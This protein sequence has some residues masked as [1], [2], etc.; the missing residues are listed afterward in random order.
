[1]AILALIAGV[2]G[3]VFGFSHLKDHAGGGGAGDDDVLRGDGEHFGE[4]SVSG[5]GG[6]GNAG[7]EH[8]LR[9]IGKRDGTD[10]VASCGNSKSFMIG[11]GIVQGRLKHAGIVAAVAGIAEGQ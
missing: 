4:R 5:I 10:V 1:M 6:H 9:I 8:E 7:I 2:L 11:G 3:N